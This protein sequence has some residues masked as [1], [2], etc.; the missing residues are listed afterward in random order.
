[1]NTNIL[2]LGIAGIVLLLAL[3]RIL[4]RDNNNT[5]PSAVY[6][7]KGTDDLPEDMLADLMKKARRK[8]KKG[9][10]R[11]VGS[12][13][14]RMAKQLYNE[15]P[16]PRGA[17]PTSQQMWDSVVV[18]VKSNE[19]TIMLMFKVIIACTPN[20]KKSNEGPAHEQCPKSGSDARRYKAAGKRWGKRLANMNLG[21]SSLGVTGALVIYKYISF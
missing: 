7:P 19:K 3:L 12:P 13:E 2:V 11:V 20:N 21:L 17:G 5:G 1:M 4:R 14:E 10:Y 18:D 16:M 8:L 9:Y 15:F 6:G